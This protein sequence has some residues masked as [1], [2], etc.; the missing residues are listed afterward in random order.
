M[1]TNTVKP[2]KKKGILFIL[3]LFI[4]CYCFIYLF[5]VI[6]LFLFILCYCFILF[7]LCYCFILFILCY[8]FILCYKIV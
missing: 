4:L 8:C 5:N 2:D 1:T 7:I 6:V 3:Y